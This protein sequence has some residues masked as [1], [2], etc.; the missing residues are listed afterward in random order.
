[1]DDI[2][3]PFIKVGIKGVNKLLNITKANKNAY[4]SLMNLCKFNKSTGHCKESFTKK[5]I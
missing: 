3:L 5:S 4:T 2:H 1:M